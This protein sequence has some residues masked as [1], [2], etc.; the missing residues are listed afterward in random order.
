MNAQEEKSIIYPKYLK[1]NSGFYLDCNTVFA[2][3]L[4]G[5]LRVRKMGSFFPT[6]YFG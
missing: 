3:A 5:G 2:V 1:L 4:K 6:V